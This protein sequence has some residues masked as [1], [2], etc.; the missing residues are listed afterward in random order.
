MRI[1]NDELDE[2][3]AQHRR[4]DDIW[5]PIV[6]AQAHYHGP[7]VTRLISQAATAEERF[8]QEELENFSETRVVRR[9]GH[10]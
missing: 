10:R 6:E 9:R 7:S 4:I 2:M 3:E 1:L 5:D 8:A